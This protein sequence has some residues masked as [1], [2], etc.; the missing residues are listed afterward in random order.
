[1]LRYDI[2]ITCPACSCEHSHGATIDL[3]N[4]PNMRTTVNAAYPGKREPLNLLLLLVKEVFC[5]NA[6]RFVRQIDME[7][8]FLVPRPSTRQL[9]KKPI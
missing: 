3:A 9:E 6:G 1:M 8:V 2:R 4:G 5:L 7:K